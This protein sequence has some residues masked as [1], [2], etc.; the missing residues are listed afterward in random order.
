MPYRAAVIRGRVQ[1]VGFRAYVF[2][3]AGAHEISGEVW[4]RTDGAVETHYEHDEAAMVES[5]EAGLWRGPGRV[6]S[7]DVRDLGPMSG[8][9]GFDVGPTRRS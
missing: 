2:D 4:N 8:W 1:G 6:D 7:V 9:T 3:L 5:F